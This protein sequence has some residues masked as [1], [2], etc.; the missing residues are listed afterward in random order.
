MATVFRGISSSGRAIG[1][2]SIGGRFESDILH[3]KQPVS[4]AFFLHFFDEGGFMVKQFAKFFRALNANSKPSEIAHALCLGVILG[5]MP[6]NNVLWYLIFVF[7][8]FVRINKGFYFLAALVVSQFAWIFD[9]VFND[10]GL[11]VLHY[12]AFENF[13]ARIID[14]PFVGFTRFNNSIVM[15]SLVVSLVAYI[16]VF[17]LGI[18]FVKLWR[19]V[20]SP[21]IVKLPI[22]KIVAKLPIVE[23]ISSLDIIPEDLQ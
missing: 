5:L 8:M 2:Q 10:V 23:K 22:V 13:F 21:A 12:Q 3:W 6:K 1:S 15:G 19:T 14:I 11:A 9:D 18:L 4:V 7:F 16:P 17:V 20:L